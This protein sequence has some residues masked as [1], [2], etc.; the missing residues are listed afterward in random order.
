MRWEQASAEATMTPDDEASVAAITSR[1]PARPAAPRTTAQKN[2]MTAQ[3][4]CTTIGELS[5]VTAGTGSTER[6]RSYHTQ[7]F[8]TNTRVPHY[9]AM[10]RRVLGALV[11][12]GLGNF[13][14]LQ[15]C[16]VESLGRR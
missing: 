16:Q 3:Y 10:P 15:V 14:R 12:M 5:E 7:R 4:S 6:L 2:Y 1:S 8:L 13:F 11:T 9:P